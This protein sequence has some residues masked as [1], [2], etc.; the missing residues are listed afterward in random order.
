MV[1]DIVEQPKISCADVCA[2]MP[3]LCAG[4]SSLTQACV[5][6]KHAQLC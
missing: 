6:S 1:S 5:N 2:S 3:A 4:A